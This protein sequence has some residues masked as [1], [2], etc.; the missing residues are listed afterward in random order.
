MYAVIVS[1]G[2]QYRVQEGHTLKLEKLAVEAVQTLNL[3]VFF[4][5][6][7]VTMLKSAR[8]L[9]KVLRLQLRLL[10]TVA[11]RKFIS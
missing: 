8:Q 5:L 6:L 11:L 7:M 10:A 4:L 1:G 9:L 2:K 3:I